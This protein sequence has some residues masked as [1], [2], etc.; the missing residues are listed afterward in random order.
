[1]H[2]PRLWT[3]APVAKRESEGEKQSRGQRKDQRKHTRSK[4]HTDNEEEET[5]RP[6]KEQQDTRTERQPKEAPGRQRKTGRRR[7]HTSH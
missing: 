3:D 1:M 5:G 4:T 6:P 2:L 7:L